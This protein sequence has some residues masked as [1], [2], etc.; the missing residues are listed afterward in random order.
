MGRKRTQNGLVTLVTTKKVD[1]ARSSKT[2]FC[3]TIHC[4]IYVRFGR[5]MCWSGQYEV[6]GVMYYQNTYCARCNATSKMR[7]VV[8][9]ICSGPDI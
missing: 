9:I 8:E 6:F 3:I 5:Q 4:T 1:L 7:F 2:G